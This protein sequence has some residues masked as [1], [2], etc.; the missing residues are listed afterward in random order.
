[1]TT[2]IRYSLTGYADELDISAAGN[3]E[4]SFSLGEVDVS[5]TPI[6]KDGF[7]TG[8]C[9]IT[10]TTTRAASQL[11][12]AEFRARAQQVAEETSAGLRASNRKVKPD[13]RHAEADVSRNL[14]A[15]LA[16]RIQIDEFRTMSRELSDPEVEWILHPPRE[17]VELCE[18]V[19]LELHGAASRVV[20]I[21]RWMFNRT[22]PAQAISRETLV[23]SIGDESWY[24][25]ASTYVDTETLGGEGQYLDEAV[26]Q[27][28]QQV[29][30]HDD[31]FNEPLAHQIFLEAVALQDENPR[32]SLTLAAAAAEVGIK[33][34]AIAQTSSASEKWLIT[35]LQSPPIL[36]LVREYLPSL[37]EKRT[38]DNRAIPKEIQTLLHDAASSRNDVVHQGVDGPDPERLAAFL[39]ATNDFLYLLD[40]FAGHNWAWRRLRQQTRAAYELAPE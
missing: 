36:R 13:H 23:W 19:R 1:M 17:I 16:G 38:F 39:A 35:E 40:W 25:A 18:D 8:S 24:E 34:F 9:M 22:S 30:N 15:L 12:M 27:L 11:V 3:D 7:D 33:Q 21:L 26:L 29:L 2:Q 31:H 14:R 32:A 20:Q 37:T 28:M 10:A 6:L 5:L 4:A